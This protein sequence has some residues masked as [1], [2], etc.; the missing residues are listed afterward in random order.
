MRT[1]KGKIAGSLLAWLIAATASVA[2]AADTPVDRLKSGDVLLL[3]HAL[4]P[5]T[6]DPPN[7]RVEDC[8]TQRNLNDAGRQQAKGIGNWLRQRGIEQARVYSSQWCRCLETAELMGLGEVTPL[9]ALNS[10][11]QDR[12]AKPSRIAAL[13]DFL[14]AQRGQDTPLVL[15]THQVTVSAMT[16]LFTSSGGGVVAEIGEGGE[17]S[18]FARLD[19]DN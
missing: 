17:L 6:G 11:F 1:F 15:V 5:G 13:R 4:A 18:G 8:S 10:F 12:S 16:G 19:F 9:P 2:V 14:D 7:F 3:R